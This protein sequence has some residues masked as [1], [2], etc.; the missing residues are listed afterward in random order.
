MY[1]LGH[2]ITHRRWPYLIGGGV[3]LLCLIVSSVWASHFF[4]AKTILNQ[5]RP[6]THYITATNTTTQHIVE[7][8]FTVDIPSEWHAVP[9]SQTISGAYGWQGVST[10][11]SGRRLD[12]YIDTVPTT[13]AANRVLPVQ[14]VGDGLQ[15]NG[16]VS[17]NCADFADKSKESVATATA[18]AAW[19]GVAFVC[20]LGN[21]ERDV[22]VIGT[23]AG[24]NDVAIKGR[25]TGLHHIML[26][27]TDDSI[28]PDYSVFMAIIRSFQVR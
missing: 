13:L 15:S 17:D 5:S 2:H 9:S 16:A 18:P 21:Y 19:N 28:T 6:V 26:V 7:H 11:G 25:T 1:H 12:V 23:P 20:D 3:L 14:V 8:T 27:Y 4:I 10:D 22:V 24:V